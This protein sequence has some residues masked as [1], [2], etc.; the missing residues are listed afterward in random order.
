MWMG[1]QS[2]NKLD[3]GASE[4]LDQTLHN[5]NFRS[6]VKAK[7]KV[8]HETESVAVTALVLCAH[9]H[10]MYQPQSLESYSSWNTYDTLLFGH[11]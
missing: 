2:E 8:R 4:F 7:W 5:T 9:Q 11:Q 10:T 3:L 6:V 1:L